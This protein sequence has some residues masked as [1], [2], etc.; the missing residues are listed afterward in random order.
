MGIDVNGRASQFRPNDRRIRV[1]VEQPDA[2]QTNPCL[3][4]GFRF[5]DVYLIN[6]QLVV[7][8]SYFV[9]STLQRYRQRYTSYKRT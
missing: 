5:T 1:F 7:E 8:T 6:Y 9:E 3:N 2:V 4:Q